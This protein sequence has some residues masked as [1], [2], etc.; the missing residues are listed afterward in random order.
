MKIDLANFSE[1]RHKKGFAMTIIFSNN[2]DPDCQVIKQAWQDLKDI[3][4]VEITPDTDDYEDLVNNA[5]IAEDDTIMFVGHGTSK[6]LLFPNLYRMEYLLHEFNANLV[7]AKNIICCWCFASDF[8]ISMNWHN[9]FATSMFISNIRE[10]CDNS[11]IDYTQKQINS[12]G[13]RF[14]CDINQLIKNK[15]PLN[16]WIMQLG[17]KMDI[18]NVIDTFNRQGLYYN[19]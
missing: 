12:N 3:N 16:D 1:E 4:L 17:A 13:E 14:F 7:H 19:K 18:E 5:I 2:M 10:A 15:V 9:T 11:I 6:G 8:V